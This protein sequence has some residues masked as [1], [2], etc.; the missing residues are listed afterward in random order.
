MKA[1]LISY[2]NATNITIAE[3]FKPKEGWIRIWG[4]SL[5]NLTLNNVLKAKNEG[6]THINV[7]LIDEFGIEKYPDFTISE[8][9]K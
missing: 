3:V 8:L 6:V 4:Q 7:R 9:I 1:V 2:P 5:V